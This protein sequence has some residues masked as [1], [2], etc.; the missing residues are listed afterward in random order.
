METPLDPRNPPPLRPELR[1][2]AKPRDDDEPDRLENPLLDF[3]NELLNPLEL[4]LLETY[5]LR[6]DDGLVTAFLKLEGAAFAILD[7]YCLLAETWLANALLPRY[8]SRWL[9]IPL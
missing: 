7:S 9:R 6:I 1:E 5:F 8:V 4:F 3:F 2:E